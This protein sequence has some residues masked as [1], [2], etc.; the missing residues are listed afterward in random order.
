MFTFV[1]LSYFVSKKYDWQTCFLGE[2]KCTFYFLFKTIT[3]YFMLF[4]VIGSF[5][6]PRTDV[7]T[8]GKQKNL[9]KWARLQRL[10]FT[11]C[12]NSDSIVIIRQVHSIP[13]LLFL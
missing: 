3:D 7:K 8:S 1:I 5:L 13:N 4:C 12:S 2:K 11:N 6:S 10:L 9:Y